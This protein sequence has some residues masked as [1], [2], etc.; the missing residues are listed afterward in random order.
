MTDNKTLRKRIIEQAYAYNL[1]HSASAL[2][3]LDCIAFLYDHVMQPKD[4][5][6]LSK[7]HG[8]MAL[9]A[10]LE[11][12]G[13][14]VEWSVHPEYDPSREILATTGSLGHG[15]PLGVGRAYAMKKKREDGRVFVVLGD[16]EMAEGSN[17]EAL[18][19]ANALNVNLTAIVDLNNKGVLGPISEYGLGEAAIYNRLSAYG[20]RTQ[21]IEGHT[22][23]SLSVLKIPQEGLQGIVMRTKRGKGIPVLESFEGHHYDWRAHQAEYEATIRFLSR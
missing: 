6:I 21:I 12:K 10:V 7:G 3:A 15:L 19:L 1:P 16:A 23:A 20:C 11:K 8:A 17:W 5:F 2:S 13:I 9:Y 4:R 14:P 18:N 22:E